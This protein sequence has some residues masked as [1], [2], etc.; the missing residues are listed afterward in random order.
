MLCNSFI[1]TIY[2]WIYF[3]GDLK[4]PTLPKQL[5]SV[6]EFESVFF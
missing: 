4:A 1:K 5:R 3:P 6:C 2:T